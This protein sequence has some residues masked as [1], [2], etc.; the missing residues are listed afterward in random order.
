MKISI[1]LPSVFPDHLAKALDMIYATTQGVDYEVV[2]VS[3]FEV[4]KPKVRWVHE[5]EPRGTVPA[6]VTAYKHAVGEFVLGF[7]DDVELL[8][9]WAPRA[10]G[11]YE[12][13]AAGH[14]LFCLGLWARNRIVSTVF[15][16]YYANF[17]FVRRTMLDQIGGY[18]HDRY[19]A[20]F[21]DPDLSLRVWAGGGRCEFSEA[22]LMVAEP[23]SGPL[24]DPGKTRRFISLDQDMAVFLSRWKEKFGAGWDTSHVHGFVLDINPAIQLT[25]ARDNTICFND[26]RFKELYDNYQVNIWQCRVAMTFPD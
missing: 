14:K 8:P 5:A 25:V 13:R 18:F 3:P 24:R 17:P 19:Q 26:P 20:H 23:E 6:H 12:R 2:V 10:L 15:G 16:L 9:D 7:S 4:N 21:A 1:I 11:N 22:P